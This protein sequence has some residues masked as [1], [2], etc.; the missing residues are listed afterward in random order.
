MCHVN[1]SQVNNVIL[2]F[3]PTVLFH[4][5]S[6]NNYK[7]CNQQAIKLPQTQ[8]LTNLKPT[9]EDFFIHCNRHKM[10]IIHH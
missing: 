8:N 6:T 4:I 7:V 5:S 10:V 9:L 3:K 2:I 1:E